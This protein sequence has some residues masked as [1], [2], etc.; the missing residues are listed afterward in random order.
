MAMNE[1]EPYFQTG[2]NARK[3]RGLLAANHGDERCANFSWQRSRPARSLQSVRCRTQLEPG[4]TRSASRV[5]ATK[6][7]WAIA[8]SIPISN[9]RRRRR[10]VIIIA[11]RIRSTLTHRRVSLT[12]G[13]RI[14]INRLIVRSEPASHHRGP[15]GSFAIAACLRT[16]RAPWKTLSHT[17]EM[18]SRSDSI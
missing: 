13:S 15:A 12:P 3:R 2:A 14:F 17:G 1:V 5:V 11:T 9:V 7:P 18:R 6:A 16:R 10:V 4:I 8:A